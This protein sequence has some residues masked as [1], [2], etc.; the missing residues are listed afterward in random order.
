MTHSPPAWQPPDEP[1]DPRLD[2]V[3]QHID[4]LLRATA[5]REVPA[6]LVSRVAEASTAALER[7]RATQ[8]RRLIFSPVAQLAAAAVMGLAVV[9]LFWVVDRGPSLPE[10]TLGP[11]M[12]ALK[13]PSAQARH[14]FERFRGLQ[15]VESLHYSDAIDGLESVVS[16]IQWGAGGRL[17]LSEGVRERD[18]FEN[19]LDAV[20]VVARLGG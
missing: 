20:R 8:P 13:Q 17:V 3:D 19:E 4:D 6:G 18:T 10:V 2:E 11:S 1:A 14:P 5:P 12:A 7:G 16:A 9:G 15:L